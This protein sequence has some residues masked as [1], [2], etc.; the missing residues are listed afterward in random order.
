MLIKELCRFIEERHNIFIRKT[1]KMQKPWTDD[2]I[3][4]TYRFCNVYR[5]L[6]TVT[7]WI[8]NNW[9][10]PHQADPFLW[11]AMVVARLVNWPDTLQAIGYPVPW[12]P[13]KF[14]LSM[15]ARKDAGEKVFSGAYIV[16]TNGHAMDKAV[17]LVEHVLNPLWAERNSISK[18][19]QY[20]PRLAAVHKL[21]ASYNGLGS[22]M[23]AQVIADL[24]YVRPLWKAEDWDFWAAS[25]PGSR[26]GLNRVYGRP[27]DAPWKE[28]VW[29]A[30]LHALHIA[31]SGFTST[32]K[33]PTLH[34][35]DL[36]NCL[37]E[38]D[39]Y[40]RVKLGEGRPRSLYPGGA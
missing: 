3:L 36:Q 19:I 38:F 18:S 31:V 9:R 2:P 12:K 39:K 25:G 26:R 8:S 1:A 32:H 11:F 15:H 13:A 14:V 33:M 20:V 10:G 4:P 16:S 7:K 40:M 6:D 22:F 24:K 5:E 21:L 29:L 34:A 30:T 27:V 35:Q 37:C 28:D 23:A 17:Y